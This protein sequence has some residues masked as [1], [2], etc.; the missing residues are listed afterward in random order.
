MNYKKDYPKGSQSLNELLARFPQSRWAKVANYYLYLCYKQEGK[1]DL[2]Q[3]YY[4]KLNWE[5]LD[6]PF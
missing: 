4:R 5:L 1:D 6:I 2:A 3:N